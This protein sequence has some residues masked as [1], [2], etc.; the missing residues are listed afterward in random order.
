MMTGITGVSKTIKLRHCPVSRRFA[1]SGRHS[2]HT[3]RT[4]AVNVWEDSCFHS[5]TTGA[6]APGVPVLSIVG[7]VWPLRSVE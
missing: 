5:H 7:Q 2:F 6:T 1:I 4:V 3:L